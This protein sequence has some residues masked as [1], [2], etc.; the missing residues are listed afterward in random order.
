MHSLLKLALWWLSYV[1]CDSTNIYC[2]CTSHLI[3]VKKYRIRQ[4][5][6][7]Y[8]LI[9]EG[10]VDFVSCAAASLSTVELASQWGVCYLEGCISLCPTK[11][12]DSWLSLFTSFLSHH[13]S[14]L[15]PVWKVT[16]FRIPWAVFPRTASLLAGLHTR[17]CRGLCWE[18]HSQRRQSPSL[19]EKPP[20]GCWQEEVLCNHLCRGTHVCPCPSLPG[21]RGLGFP[22]RLLLPCPCRLAL[23]R[24]GW[25]GALLPA[26]WLLFI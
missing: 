5:R 14:P 6:A 4:R 13:L 16:G 18:E 8:F 12:G 22:H 2:S 20:K 11:E 9:T 17:T 26:A 1:S 15:T 19:S 23:S 3:I 7:V 21:Q 25:R 24:R 10:Q